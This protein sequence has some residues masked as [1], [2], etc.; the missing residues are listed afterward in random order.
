MTAP[1]RDDERLV[2][3]WPPYMLY[4]AS[5]D[6]GRPVPTVVRVLPPSD[7]SVVEDV[8]VVETWS[9]NIVHRNLVAFGAQLMLDA[10]DTTIRRRT[11]T[12][13][14]M[15]SWI[16]DTRAMSQRL[17]YGGPT[18]QRLENA[19]RHVEQLIEWPAT[20]LLSAPSSPTKAAELR[21]SLYF[22]SCETLRLA[23]NES[24]RARAA[25]GS[26]RGSTVTARRIPAV[27]YW[28]RHF[29]KPLAWVPDEH[30]PL[31]ETKN[32]EKRIARLR[33]QIMP[34]S[35][36]TL[37]GEVLRDVL[38]YGPILADGTA[39]QT[40]IIKADRTSTPVTGLK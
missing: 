12:F 17:P 28:D 4:A 26:R 25:L 31:L 20:H 33:K 16:A 2:H 6:H 29:G 27:G 8:H 19:A 13:A 21:V 14:H 38:T 32:I 5:P 37:M 22:W 23:V 3:I 18:R 24:E 40:L 1:T 7:L 39:R 34:G 11:P 35:E 9:V 15:R 30:R 10:N 36:H